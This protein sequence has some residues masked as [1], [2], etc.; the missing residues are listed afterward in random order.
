MNLHSKNAE[1][2]SSNFCTQVSYDSIQL[3]N[4]V[5]R[6]YGECHFHFISI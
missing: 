5:E 1:L 3:V 6:K 4:Y 2:N